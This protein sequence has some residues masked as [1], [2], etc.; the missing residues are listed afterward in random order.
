MSLS[1]LCVKGCFVPFLF[2]THK[3]V[4]IMLARGQIVR[5]AVQVTCTGWDGF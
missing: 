2:T 1:Y 3:H 4:L 5:G